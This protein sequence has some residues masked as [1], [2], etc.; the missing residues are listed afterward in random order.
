MLTF[1]YD[2]L[3]HASNQQLWL[4]VQDLYNIKPVKIPACIGEGSDVPPL[5]VEL[6]AVDG[7]TERESYS[8]LKKCPKSLRLMD[9][10]NG[11]QGLLITK[12]RT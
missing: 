3:L 9:S 12:K 8:T 5:A 10:T 7:Y 11:T 4:S 1:V 2:V 6:L